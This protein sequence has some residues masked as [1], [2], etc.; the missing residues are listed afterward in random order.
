MTTKIHIGA[1]H[2]GFELKEKLARFLE[3]LNYEVTDYGAYEYDEDDDYPDFIFPVAK[4]V[5]L[6]PESKGIVIGG[7]G[8]GEAIAANRIA[9]IRAV[10]FNGQYEPKDGREVPDE[11][12][13]SR[14]HNDANVLSLGA[15]FLSTEEAQEAVESWL[16]T[17]FS[18]DERHV[19]RIAKIDQLG[20]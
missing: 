14:E 9:G 17:E 12:V 7:S 18:G 8:Q 19:R 6:D 20:L 5:L 10:V 3:K 15:R 13:L 16:N 4:A 11:I 2:A 1:D